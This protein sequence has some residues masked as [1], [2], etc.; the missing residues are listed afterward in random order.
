MYIFVF[1][2]FLVSAFWMNKPYVAN[3]LS[4]SGIEQA[5][6]GLESSPL[7]LRIFL[8]A[9][10]IATITVCEISPQLKPWASKS[11][12]NISKA[13][14]LRALFK[15]DGFPCA[16]IFYFF[17]GYISF[18]SSIIVLGSE[19]V[20]PFLSQII[21]NPI[22]E[23]LDT[24][25]SPSG[26]FWVALT[27]ASG[28]FLHYW[29]HRIHHEFSP[30]W[31]IHELHHSATH[32]SGFTVLRTSPLEQLIK[33]L[34]FLPLA[35]PIAWASSKAIESLSIYSVIVFTLF[36]AYKHINQWVGHSSLYLCLPKPLSL[37]LMSPCD[38]WVH[39]SKDH[40]HFN[41]NYGTFL[42]CWDQIFGTYVGISEVQAKAISFGVNNTSYNRYNPMIEYFLLPLILF[43]REI[44]KLGISLINPQ[45]EDNFTSTNSSRTP[46]KNKG[47]ENFS[48]ENKAINERI[49]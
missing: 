38:H 1:S 20:I 34:I 37:V 9:I 22:L 48:T 43:T 40:R 35:I 19:K 18:L 24:R 33:A 28:D 2:L 30:L 25:F 27:F 10:P 5:I 49:R 46:Y 11:S 16:D 26:I 3:S 45:H 39:H 4:G 36:T 17:I 29:G 32:M 42:K 13:R 8:A 23:F 47:I 21:S 14:T 7:I 15:A 6:V 44:I 12:I 41:K 31:K